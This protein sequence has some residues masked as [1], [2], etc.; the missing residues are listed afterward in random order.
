V[1]S[2]D[3]VQYPG[4]YVADVISGCRIQVDGSSD[5]LRGTGVDHFVY[6]FQRDLDGVASYFTTRQP[7]P[8]NQNQTSGSSDPAQVK[9]LWKKNLYKKST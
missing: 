5:W 3:V 1:E 8:V 7:K 4:S 2:H 9:R 6:C